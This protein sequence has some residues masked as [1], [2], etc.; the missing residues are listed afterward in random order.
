MTG[1]FYT[2]RHEWVRL[3]GGAA[4]VG[5]TGKNLNGDIV[6]I[7]LP[8]PGR[9]VVSGEACARVES[10]KAE[11]E[12]CAPVLGIVTAVNDTVF[13]DP[14]MIARQPMDAWLFK[15]DPEPGAVTEGL[16]TEA[17]YKEI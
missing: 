11:L 7:E 2:S 13:D 4:L 3:N 15:V 16:L 10:V 14:D 8:E 1:L 17:E 9:R 6:Y 5:I 12:V